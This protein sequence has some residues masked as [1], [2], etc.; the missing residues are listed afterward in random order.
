MRC[1]HPR[2]ILLLTFLTGFP[3]VVSPAGRSAVA[4][5]RLW[6]RLAVSKPCA[7]HVLTMLRR[8]FLHCYIHPPPVNRRPR[9]SSV[10]S[11]LSL[12]C[13]RRACFSSSIASSTNSLAVL[14]RSAPRPTPRS[15]PPCSSVVV[16]LAVLGLLVLGTLRVVLDA[17]VAVLPLG[18]SFGAWYVVR[19][20]HCLWLVDQTSHASLWR[21]LPSLERRPE[22]VPG[23]TFLHCY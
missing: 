8:L 11:N 22:C 14:V 4:F 19:R 12:S 9:R 13:G 21:E 7:P 6:S 20:R 23:P 18:R 15:T 10:T 2:G 17:L 3:R 1:V 5:A 16:V